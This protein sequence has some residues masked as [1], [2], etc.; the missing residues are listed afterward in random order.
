MFEL[1][2]SR[3]SSFEFQRSMRA[4]FELGSTT[5]IQT[6]STPGGS[7]AQAEILVRRDLDLWIYFSERPDSRGLLQCWCGVGAPTWQAVLEVNIPTTRTLS[8]YTQLVRD[9]EGQVHLAHKGGL[10]GGK[11]SVAPDVFADLIQGFERE[12]VSD[13]KKTLSY[14]IVG[15]MA[16]PRALLRHLSEYVHEAHRIRE[17]R[18]SQSKFNSKL[19]Q[20]VGSDNGM[21]EGDGP[22]YKGEAEGGGK[23]KLER[24]VHF[25][26]LHAKV[27]R[28]LARELHGERLSYSDRRQRNGLGPDLFIRG[29]NGRMKQLFEIKVGADSQSTFTAIGQLL[30]YSAAESGPISKVLVTR[31]LPRSEQFAKVLQMQGIQVLYYDLDDRSKVKFIN[32]AQVLST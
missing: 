32:I 11:Y 5:E 10:G 2:T 12:A 19:K 3:K 1:T 24:E 25:R 9:A 13:G 17:W 31:G 29:S 15:G 28:A 8:C 21:G 4:A 26:R 6:L 18:R 30:V 23:Y 22:E 27:Q 7:I 20:L 14:F 16:A